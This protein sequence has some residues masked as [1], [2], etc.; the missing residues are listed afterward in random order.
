MILHQIKLKLEKLLKIAKKKF[1][2]INASL[3]IFFLEIAL[4]GGP[5]SLI[6]SGFTDKG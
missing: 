4:S 5:A 2:I 1:K 3:L 6:F